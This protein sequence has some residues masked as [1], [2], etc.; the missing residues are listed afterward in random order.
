MENI[1]KE[2]MDYLP[3]KTPKEGEEWTINGI[4]YVFKDNMFILKK[5]GDK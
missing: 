3:C 2:W 4:S 1:F 5:E